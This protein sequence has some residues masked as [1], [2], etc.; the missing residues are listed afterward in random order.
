MSTPPADKFWNRLVAFRDTLSAEEQAWLNG[1]IQAAYAH[2]P[3]VQG[4]TNG[5]G[6]LMPLPPH[7]SFGLDF[8]MYSLVMPQPNTTYDLSQ[9]TG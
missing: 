2:E 6:R 3:E 5:V 8:N 9:P 4:Y 1:L 7:P